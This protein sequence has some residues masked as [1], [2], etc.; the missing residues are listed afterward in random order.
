MEKLMNAKQLE[1]EII[2]AHDLN[3]VEYIRTTYIELV[4]MRN[5]MDRW[6][7]KFLDMFDEKL[8]HCEKTDPVRKLYDS[9]FD[10]YSQVSRVLKVA[11]HYM[12][13]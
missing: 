5:K 8:N 4:N 10:E 12:K 1:K 9:K 7:D 3:N 6:F 2:I 11:E 13:A